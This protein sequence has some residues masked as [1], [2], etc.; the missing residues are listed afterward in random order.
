M[1]HTMA[2]GGGTGMAAGEKLKNE[3]LG[4]KIKMGNENGG[5]LHK[6]DIEW[7]DLKIASF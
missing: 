6:K 7:K 2:E 5:K 3:N 1:Q 4:G